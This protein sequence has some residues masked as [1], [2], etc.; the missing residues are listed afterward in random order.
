MWIAGVA[1]FRKLVYPIFD[2]PLAPSVTF[3]NELHF[4]MHDIA[5][6]WDTQQ[7]LRYA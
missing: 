1:R 3:A 5:E 2:Q 7:L 6:F 4:F